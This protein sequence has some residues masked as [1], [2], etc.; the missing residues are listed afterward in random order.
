[1]GLGVHVQS[2]EK[3]VKT[4]T[5]TSEESRAQKHHILGMV[6]AL[7]YNLDKD[8]PPFPNDLEKG[9]PVHEVRKPQPF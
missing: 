3:S 5:N 9:K 4:A 2:V 1:M 6:R 8:M 7:P